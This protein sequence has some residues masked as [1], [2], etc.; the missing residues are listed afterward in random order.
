MSSVFVNYFKWFTQKDKRNG[1]IKRKKGK[2]V[3]DKTL[4][5]SK[6]MGLGLHALAN[7]TIF[8]QDPLFQQPENFADHI[9]TQ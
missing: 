9:F 1:R 7:F 6:K 5:Q 4:Y 8:S 2:K 3:L